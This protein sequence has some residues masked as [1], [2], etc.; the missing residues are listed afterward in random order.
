MKTAILA[1]GR[2]T[3]L[4]SLTHSIPKPMLKIGDKPILEH[5]IL[6]LKKYNISDII[7]C[8]GYL[9]KQIENYF[10]DGKKWGV[11][12]TYSKEN[13]PL[14][15]AG[16]IKELENKIG[17]NFLVLYGDVMVNMDLGCL[18]DYHYL[19]RASATL[20]VHPNNHPFD[21]DLVD[22]NCEY[23]ITNFLP[24]PHLEGLIF[25]N[26]VNAGVYLLSDK[27]FNY[28]KKG[29]KSDFGRDIFPMMLKKGEKLFAYNSTE[30]TKD[31]GTLGRLEEVRSDYKSFKISSLNLSNS[32]HALF[33]DRD[34]VI[35]KEVDLLYRLEDVELIP[36]AASAIKEINNT[37]YLAVI[38]SNQS[39]VARGLCS[40]EDVEMINKKLE[41]LLG[42]KG[43]KI[44]RMYFC[45]HHPDKG[46]PGENIKY[47]IDCNCRKPKIGMIEK[48]KEDLNIDLRKSFLIGDQTVDIKT[49]KNAHITSV[50]VRGGY[51]CK[52]GKYDVAPDL[53]ADDLMNAVKIIKDVKRYN[54]YIKIIN[55]RMEN[56]SSKPFV[57]AIGGIARSGKSIFSSFLKKYLAR[58]GLST[59]IID[60][61]NWIIP[62]NKRKKEQNVLDRFR[63]KNFDED[64]RR[65]LS[66]NRV[67]LKK[68]DSFVRSYWDEENTVTYDAG[69]KD[70]IIVVGTCVLNSK[71]V[72]KVSNLKIYMEF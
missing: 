65:I 12:I 10:R 72:D 70:I 41:T 5:Q 33:L 17:S 14:G 26:L 56:Y 23:K 43:A 38:I 18:I 68:Y 3:R 35:N 45:P 37:E 16:C 48:A 60:M 64:F 42:L 36:D 29:K 46:Y 39:V 61:D 57:I 25:R 13:K 20:V 66:R 11:N 59:L 27:V 2:G 30:Y 19:K 55:S 44:D 51:G 8:S 63:L 34:G 49:A 9:S 54:K 1:G 7:I 52:D 67:K 50:G 69:N 62:A 22:V 71:I 21:S 47:K 58:K 53:W 40:I 4:S 28:I 15:T 32:R 6:L 24:K 31:M